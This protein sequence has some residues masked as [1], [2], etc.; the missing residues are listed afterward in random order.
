MVSSEFHN[1]YTLARY[2]LVIMDMFYL[3][4]LL[5]FINYLR[6]IHEV[7]LNNT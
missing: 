5:S 6:V 7:A 1:K 2:S 4:L 3:D